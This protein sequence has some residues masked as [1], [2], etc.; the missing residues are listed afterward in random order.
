MMLV[1]LYSWL[2]WPSP[3]AVATPSGAGAQA[4]VE[5]TRRKLQAP[6]QQRYPG[7][8]VEATTLTGEPDSAGTV[9]PLAVI[10]HFPRGA[11]DEALAETH[12]LAWNLSQTSLL[13]TLEPTRLIAWSCQVDPLQ[14]DDRKRICELPLAPGFSAQGSP[15]QRSVRDLLHWVSLTNGHLQRRCPEYFPEEGR[16]DALLLKNLRYVRSLLIADGLE[17][18][19][20]HD[21][22][23]RVIFTQYLFHRRDSAGRAFFSPELL[24][25]LSNGP[26][27]RVHDSFESI[28]RDHAETYALFQWLDERFNG[29]LFPG[30][31]AATPEEREA[32]WQAERE[33]VTPT[34]LQFLAD[35]VS[36]TIDTTDEQLKLWP[37]YSFDT[38]P[39]EFISSIYETFLSKE[40]KLDK[41]YYTPPHLV[42]YVLDAVLPWDGTEWDL[43]ILDPSCGS[44]IFLVKAL[45]R[46]IFRWRRQHPE[47]EPLVSDLKPILA[48]NLVG[49]DKNAEAVRV[50]CFSLYLAMADAIEPRHYVTRERIFPRLRGT[51]LI[52]ADFFDESSA[53]V[54]TDS[55][56][57]SFDIVVGN[58]PWGD[59]SIK[60]TSCTGPARSFRGKPLKNS[61]TLAE[62]WALRKRWPV[63]NNDI[64]PLFLSKGLELL[65]TGGTAALVQP[66]GPWLYQRET[67]AHNLRKRL[68]ESFTIDEVTNLSFVR[69]E[70]FTEAIGP[71]CVL[72]VRNQPAQPDAELSYVVPKPP[73]SAG[74]SSRGASVV[75]VEPQDVARVSH[76]EAIEDPYVFILLSVGGRRDLALVRRLS[77]FPSLKKLKEE[78]AILSRLGVITGNREKH[79]PELEGQPYLDAPEFPDGEFL[80]LG[81]DSA[82][83]TPWTDPRVADSDSSDFEAFK[84]PQLLIKQTLS[85]GTQRLRAKIVSRTGSEWG[86]ICKKTYLSVRDLSPDE[87]HIRAACLVLNS[88]LGSYFLAVT[89]SRVSHY[90][91]EATTREILSVPLP[92]AAIETGTSLNLSEVQSFADVDEQMRR[93]FSLTE[94]EWALVEDMHELVLPELLR[95][96]PGPGREA[97]I[98]ESTNGGEPDLSRYVQTAMRVLLATFGGAAHLGATVYENPSSTGNS[99][100]PVRMVSL[101]FDAEPSLGALQLRIERIDADGLLDLLTNLHRELLTSGQPAG[102]QPGI[103]FGRVAFLFHTYNGDRGRARSL[104]IIKPDERRYWSRSQ[105]MRDAD[106]IAAVILRAAQRTGAIS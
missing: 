24:R 57:G 70:L 41:A 17:P 64:G 80:F 77:T 71:A 4:A 76:A 33:A 68:F 100:L 94:P 34:R 66:A 101:H 73:K 46:L 9:L 99:A 72:V 104:T 50:A 54:N 56:K 27:Q 11:Q 40:K 35:L 93:L 61:E 48:N 28:L 12:R 13:V 103:T 91:P 16:A 96:T 88:L 29:D 14:D 69:R 20:C 84:Q 7:L 102:E 79:L 75:A 19:F 36:G 78:K 31:D 26:L 83:V 63:A 39:L 67:R 59:G 45:Q 23:A 62:Q 37:Q 92:P 81:T 38:I 25:R 51:R 106:E 6:L 43:R 87:R 90:I 82:Q 21:L 95:Q 98:R 8:R 47:R 74:S 2:S 18:A 1:E 3:E 53:G 58:A 55:D 52:A 60:K 89:S 97:T 42:D 15:V 44:G 85:A 86:V 5:H 10:C 30:K 32:A 22:L 105:A 49:I 65:K